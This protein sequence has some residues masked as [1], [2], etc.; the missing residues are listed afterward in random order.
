MG[1]FLSRARVIGPQEFGGLGAGGEAGGHE[2]DEVCGDEGGE[3]RDDLK[4]GVWGRAMTP[5]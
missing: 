1:S 3:K 2:A 5:G 4:S